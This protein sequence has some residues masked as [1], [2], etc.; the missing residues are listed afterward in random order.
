MCLLLFTWQLGTCYLQC[1]FC[2]VVLNRI[3]KFAGAYGA[4]S[5]RLQCRLEPVEHGVGGCVWQKN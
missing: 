1:S 3:Y 2:G 4:C 5:G